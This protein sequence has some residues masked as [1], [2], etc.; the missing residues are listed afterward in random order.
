MWAYTRNSKKKY[1]QR[2]SESVI[3][4]PLFGDHLPLGICNYRHHQTIFIDLR[5]WHLR[6]VWAYMLSDLSGGCSLP[7]VV[8]LGF[9]STVFS[10][11]IW[12]PSSA[13]VVL[14]FIVIVDLFLSQSNNTGYILDWKVWGY[15]NHCDRTRKNL[16]AIIW[17]HVN[18]IRILTYLNLLSDDNQLVNLSE[19]NMNLKI[20]TSLSLLVIVVFRLC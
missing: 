15:H 16:W 20:W 1:K 11:S 5:I 13:C 6:P 2:Y 14:L 3:I 10:L 8:S 17:N 18:G 12:T 4:T 7:S 19:K 9:H